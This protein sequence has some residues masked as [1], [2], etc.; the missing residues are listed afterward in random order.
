[1]GR[2]GVPV[3]ERVPSGNI[4]ST[5]PPV[6]MRSAQLIA[7]VSPLPRSIGKAP[8]AVMILAKSAFFW[9]SSA[10]AM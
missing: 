4:P 10:L 2:P 9:K 8:S 3:F 7:P 5:P 1:M 6:M